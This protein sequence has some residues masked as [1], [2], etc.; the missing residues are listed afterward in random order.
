MQG[1]VHS[2]QPGASWSAPFPNGLSAGLVPGLYEL[3]VHQT[4]KDHPTGVVI[5]DQLGN[6]SDVFLGEGSW[7]YSVASTGGG[8]TQPNTITITP[9]SGGAGIL[10]ITLA[11]CDDGGIGQNSPIGEVC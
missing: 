11:R 10:N 2:M 3:T 1:K 6:T 9:Q 4:R 5:T 8:I 7:Y